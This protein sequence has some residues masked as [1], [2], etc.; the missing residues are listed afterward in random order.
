MRAVLVAI[1]LLFSACAVAQAQAPSTRSGWSGTLGA[2]PLLVPR[3]IGGKS[4]EAIP[5]PIAYVTYNDWFYVN[6][7]RGGAYVWGSDDKKKGIGLAIQP[8]LGFHASDGAKLAGMATRRGSL[9]G[10]P[11]FDWQGDLGA[12]SLGYFSDL[13]NTS[14]GGY[15][16]VVFNRPF[17]HDGRWDVSGTI[18]LSRLD[19][20]VVDYYFG[21]R[22]GEAAPARPSY[23]PGAAT[24]TTL[25]ITGQYNLTK[26]YA[27][28]FG[29]NVTRLGSAAADSPIVES[30]QAPLAYLG[31]GINL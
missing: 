16:D 3:Y 18:E 23:Q 8:R 14:R 22:P 7:F 4:L 21:V 6:L 30:R 11:T 10:G 9:S 26:R 5:A 19:S 25:W 17:V 31:L 13:G 27:L 20:K 1:G 24:N 15:V 29:G 2:A 28:M 12:L